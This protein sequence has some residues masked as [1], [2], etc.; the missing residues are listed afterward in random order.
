MPRFIEALL[1]NT[2]FAA[3]ARIGLTF[4]FWWSGVDKLVNFPGG[5]AE[6]AHFGLAPAWLF[7]AA[8]VLVQLAGSALIIFNRWTWLGAGALA[9][10][11]ALTIPIAHAFWTLPEPARTGEYYTVL[12]HVTVIGAFLVVAAASARQRRAQRTRLGSMRTFDP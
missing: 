5:M 10:F 6:M 4:E 2:W 8:T 3:L 1:G 11:T 7:N 12:E 9:L